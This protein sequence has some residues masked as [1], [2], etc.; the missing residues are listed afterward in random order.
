[1]KNNELNI[2]KTKLFEITQLER[3]LTADN[4]YYFI[5]NIDQ[6]YF[7]DKE[8]VRMTNSL[9][10]GRFYFKDDLELEVVEL[11]INKMK[12]KN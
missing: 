12:N 1:M 4:Y 8:L 3:P 7:N 2:I 10:Y 11:I 5:N 6:V 9:L